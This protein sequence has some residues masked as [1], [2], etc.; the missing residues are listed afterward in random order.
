MIWFFW[1]GIVCTNLWYL[2][3]IFN[4]FTTI[5]IKCTSQSASRT[6]RKRKRRPNPKEPQSR[7]EMSFQWDLWSLSHSLVAGQL[8]RPFRVAG[9]RSVALDWLGSG[10]GP[11]FLFINGPFVWFCFWS[12]WVP[13]SH[14]SIS[15]AAILG[16]DL[17]RQSWKHNSVALVSFLELIT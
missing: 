11:L 6:L 10:T 14:Q 13:R 8:H 4:M 16:F 5:Y 1:L 2:I 9:I 3:S 15:S 17:L 12:R 7:S